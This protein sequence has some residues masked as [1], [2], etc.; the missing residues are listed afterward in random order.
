MSLYSLFVAA[1]LWMCLAAALGLF[2]PWRR[3]AFPVAA[4]PPCVTWALLL[5]IYRGGSS[6]IL[7]LPIAG[8]IAIIAIAYWL[9]LW[10]VSST[11]GA[12]PLSHKKVAWRRRSF[13]DP[14][15]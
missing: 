1:T 9:A 15:D 3:I 7:V 13:R 5:L 10:A 14:K 12:D 8:V 2:A 6:L 4:V 11:I